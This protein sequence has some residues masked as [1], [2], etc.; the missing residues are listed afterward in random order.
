MIEY[1]QVLVTW[2]DDDAQDEMLTKVCINKDW[3]EGEDDTDVFFYFTSSDELEQAKQPEPN[4]F[5][6][7]LREEE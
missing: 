7:R 3:T 2:H 6:F 1:R 4:G 5:E